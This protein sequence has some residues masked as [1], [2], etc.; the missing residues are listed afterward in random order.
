MSF[1]ISL[2]ICKNTTQS[3]CSWQTAPALCLRSTVGSAPVAPKKRLI[4]MKSHA[5]QPQEGTRLEEAF[6]VSERSITYHPSLHSTDCNN[7]KYQNAVSGKCY[8]P[9]TAPQEPEGTVLAV[10]SVGTIS[11]EVEHNLQPRQPCLGTHSCCIWLQQTLFT[12]QS[13]FKV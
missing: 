11:P 4:K 13:G 3:T 9:P 12:T 5:L 1:A 7:S 6:P 2:H 10:T 8:S